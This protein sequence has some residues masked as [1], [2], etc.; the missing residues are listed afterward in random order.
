MVWSWIPYRNF[1]EATIV[2]LRRNIREKY[3]QL[4]KK[5]SKIFSF[6]KHVRDHIFFKYVNKIKYPKRMKQQKRESVIFY[7]TRQKCI[8][9]YT[10]MSFFSL[11]SLIGNIA[12]FHKNVT[13]ML[14]WNRF[15]F[16]FNKLIFKIFPGIIV[17]IVNSNRYKLT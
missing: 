11:N 1:Y 3:P 16:L 15:I 5:S 7:L 10:T 2:R 4:S 12:I 9:K 14:T 8:A 13:F 17:N 6:V